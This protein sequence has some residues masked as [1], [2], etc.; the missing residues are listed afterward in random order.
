[1]N[2]KSLNNLNK[3]K[4]FDKHPE[5]IN[6]NGRPRRFV[7]TVIKELE[8]LGIEKVKPS[9]V[10]DLYETLLNCTIEKLTEL[11]NDVNA[12]WEVR[13]TAKYMIKFPEKAWKE[14]KDRVH[15]LPK[16]QTEITGKD[17]KDLIPPTITQ[18]EIIKTTK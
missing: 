2:K 16:Q 1:M 10:I 4:S 3:R 18:I 14:M 6:K 5:F 13:Q 12:G 17:G 9:Q 11:A 15:G 8:L 7:S